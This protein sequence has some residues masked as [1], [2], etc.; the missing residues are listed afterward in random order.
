[1]HTNLSL[2]LIKYNLGYNFSFVLTLIIFLIGSA[3]TC[4]NRH[5]GKNGFTANKREFYDPRRRN[6]SAKDGRLRH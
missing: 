3:K 4:I 1:M 2:L 5:C 6:L